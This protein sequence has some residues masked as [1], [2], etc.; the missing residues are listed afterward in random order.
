MILPIAT[1]IAVAAMMLAELWLSR[2]NERWM[3]DHG[4]VA[5]PDPV[6][7]TMKWAY[8]SAFIAMAAEGVIVG[9]PSEGAAIAGVILLVLAK[10]VKFWAIASLGKRWTYR[11]LMM[12]GAP[13]VA[14]GPYRFIRHPNY[15]GVVGELIAMAL[16]S[17]ARVSG[18][19]A[20]LGFG[21][22]LIQRIRAEERALGL[23]A[24]A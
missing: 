7:A 5:A 23:R 14:S 12:P 4:A 1:L 18:P 9:G 13:L 24:G 6:Y 15:V 19:V 2:S 17:G 10:A 3:F 21:W 11:V 20:L 22:L 16:L 8:P